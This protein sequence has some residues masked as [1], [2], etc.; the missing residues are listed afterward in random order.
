LNGGV[1]IEAHYPPIVLHLYFLTT[2]I[3]FHWGQR[4]IHVDR[5]A[6]FPVVFGAAFDLNDSNPMLIHHAASRSFGRWHDPKKQY[7]REQ[8]SKIFHFQKD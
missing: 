7:E 5:S 6:I 8:Q 3:E 4:S 1:T 2:I